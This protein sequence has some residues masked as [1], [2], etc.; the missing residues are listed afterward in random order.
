[1][2]IRHWIQT[3]FQLWQK[4][5]FYQLRSESTTVCLRKNIFIRVI[6]NFGFRFGVLMDQ[7]S[8]ALRF[9]R[10]WSR[11][12]IHFLSQ[13]VFRLVQISPNKGWS[14]FWSPIILGVQQLRIFIW[15]WNRE[16][17][18]TNKRCSRNRFSPK[19]SLFFLPYHPLDKLHE[20]SKSKSPPFWDCVNEASLI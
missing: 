16:G 12:W 6:T 7:K 13:L 2:L 4:T 10:S 9:V 11:L 15:H 18:E 8:E 19:T 17:P 5:G 20:N 14:T 3:H 1:M